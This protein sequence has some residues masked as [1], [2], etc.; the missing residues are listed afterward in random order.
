MMLKFHQSPVASQQVDSPEPENKQEP[1]ESTETTTSTLP[2]QVG[3][4]SMPPQT[5]PPSL[6]E[7]DFFQ[8]D[9]FTDRKPLQ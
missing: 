9:P 8:S 4:R 6:P 2:P 7:I 3:P 1:A 5:N